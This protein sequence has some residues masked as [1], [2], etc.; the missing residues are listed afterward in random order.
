M[1]SIPH[2]NNAKLEYE[3][4][5]TFEY[6]E[7][8]WDENANGMGGLNFTPPIQGWKHGKVYN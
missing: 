4:K 8:S 2:N 5:S 1:F 3:G 6:D 7:S